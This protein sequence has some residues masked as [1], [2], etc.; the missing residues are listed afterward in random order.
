[1]TN[2]PASDIFKAKALRIKGD[3]PAATGLQSAPMRRGYVPFIPLRSDAKLF[4]APELFGKYCSCKIAA[5]KY[6]GS[7]SFHE[8]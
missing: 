7:T 8:G 6:T 5:K 2:I 1:M 4:Y 3:I